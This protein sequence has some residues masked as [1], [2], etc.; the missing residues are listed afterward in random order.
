MERTYRAFA[1]CALGIEKVLQ[2]ELERLG[3]KPEGRAPGRVYFEAD[4]AGLFRANLCLR[5]AERVLL[6]AARFKAPDFDAL[7]E[8]ARAPEWELFIDREDRLVIERV[9]TRDSQ[10]ASQT[11]VQSMVQKA[12]YE[13]LGEVYKLERMPETGSTRSARIYIEDDECTIGLDLSGE[14]LHKRGYRRSSVEAPLKE[15]IAAASLFLAGW[16]RKIP[17]MDVFCGSGTILIEAGLFGLDIAP[18]LGRSFAMEGMPFAN[19]SVF[20]AEREAARGR[21]R[22]DVD[23]MLKGSDTDEAALSAAKLNAKLAGLEGKIVFE[24]ARAQDA[25]APAGME[26]GYLVCNPP[27]GNRLGTEAEAEEIYRALGETA[28]RFKGWGLGFITNR[29]DFGSFFGR[30]AIAEHKM[31][32]GAEEQ[33]LH[34]FPPGWEDTKPRPLYVPEEDEAAPAAASARGR[35]GPRKEASFGGAPRSRGGERQDRGGYRDRPSGDRRDGGRRDGDGY[36]D[37]ERNYNDRDNRQGD[38]YDRG[39]RPGDRNDR[40]SRPFERPD[41]PFGRP[42]GQDR[43]ESRGDGRG[44]D[45]WNDRGNRPSGRYDRDS[46]PT[47]RNSGSSG[48]YGRDESRGPGYRTSGSGDRYDRGGYG[49]ADRDRPNNHSYDDRGREGGERRENESGGGRAPNYWRKD[50]DQYRRETGHSGNEGRPRDNE[51]PRDGDSRHGGYDRDRRQDGYRG[52]GDGRRDDRDRA[53]YGRR[54]SYH[55][56][57]GPRDEGGRKPWSQDGARR[58]GPPRGGDRP[59]RPGAPR[60]GRPYRDDRQPPRSGPSPRRDDGNTDD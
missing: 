53:P 19:A 24:K 50:G 26:A 22:K 46:R 29:H 27:Y 1:L 44:R 59:Y 36:R 13:R 41:R 48:R 52:Q 15:T 47:D 12:V 55:H 18:G 42:A 25:S 32:N 2:N 38:R 45:N 60:T 6:E 16:N 34:W 9:R 54:D 23:L 43:P 8:G 17:L 39:S 35:G 33:W 28:K 3:L 30:R 14:A 37:R 4:I 5:T 40:G 31:M 57:A 51:G 21:I 7:F 10:V 56:S 49:H 20:E 11:T 58:D